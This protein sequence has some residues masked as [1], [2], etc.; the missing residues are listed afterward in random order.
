MKTYTMTMR[1]N[2]MQMSWYTDLKCC[3]NDLIYYDYVMIN[4]ENENQ[5]K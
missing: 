3:E 2:R 4:Y 1:R 5:L